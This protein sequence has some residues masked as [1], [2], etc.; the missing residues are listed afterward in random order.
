M[1][2]V[3]AGTVTDQGLG[4][5]ATVTARKSWSGGWKSW[6][7]RFSNRFGLIE[8]YYV[9]CRFAS[10]KLARKTGFCDTDETSRSHTRLSYNHLV[11]KRY[12]HKIWDTNEGLNFEFDFTSNVEQAAHCSSR[13]EAQA[14]IE[15]LKAAHTKFSCDGIIKSHFPC[16]TLQIEE[17]TPVKFVIAF[18]DL[19][20]H[21]HS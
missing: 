16:E 4:L 3:A 19:T 13:E 6:A 1:I 14:Q 12:I 8:R 20:L 18:D 2:G 17:I 7:H 15:V 9:G 11:S 21:V 5:A 10:P